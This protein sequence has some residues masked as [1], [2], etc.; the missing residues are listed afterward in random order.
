MDK[1]KLIA[2]GAL[3]GVGIVMYLTK[4]PLLTDDDL[5]KPSAASTP[6]PKSVKKLDIKDTKVGTG[7][8]AAPGDTLHMLYTGKLTDGSVF[9]ST[10]KHGDQ[11]FVF[12][13]G[14]GQVIKGWDIG[15]A[16]MKKGGKRTLTI[17]SDLGYGPSGQG[18]SIPPNATLIFD[19]ELVSID[20][21]K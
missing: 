6:D 18:S 9:D 14:G 3:V 17:P 7:P 1:N 5:N 21:K 12:T 19:V 15:M 11:P 13:L 16:G 2:I 10:S 20:K 8:A 4:A